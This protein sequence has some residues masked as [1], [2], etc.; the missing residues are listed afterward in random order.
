M[1][2]LF[3]KLTKNAFIPSKHYSGDA[4]FDFYAIAFKI[5]K[6]KAY[7]ETFVYGT[8]IAIEIPKGHVGLIF[9]RS[10]I[11]NTTMSL[12]NSVGVIDENYR[13]EITFK[14]RAN[15]SLGEIYKVGDR[16]GQLLILPI[17][18]IELEEVT[19]LSESER[20]QGSYGSS[21]K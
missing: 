11:A 17:P 6:T 10:S 21:G 15:S 5:E 8:G 7:E 16:I 13:G 2:V 14:F 12:S 9:P 3:K 19:M 20:G 4:A 18:Q 1:K